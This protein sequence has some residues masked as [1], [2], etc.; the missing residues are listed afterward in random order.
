MHME[1][2]ERRDFK[3][4]EVRIEPVEGGAGRLY[5][6]SALFDSLSEDLG[7]FRERIAPGAFAATIASDDIRALFNHDSNNIL[8]RNTSGTLKLAEDDRGLVMAV[9]LPDTILARD[10]A[11][12]I[13]RGDVTGQS[14]GFRTLSDEWNM[15]DGEEIRTLKAVR[16]F[17]VGP[18]T[19]PAY[20]STTVAT[21]SLEAYRATL[22]EENKKPT[23]PP[24]AVRRASLRL[25]ELEI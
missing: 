16:L 21:R 3:F 19:F 8:G 25:A 17:D 7:G 13:E 1:L 23:F 10:L 18:V 20:P 2:L 15:E 11:V 24:L 9:D 4:L 5:G 12:S 22:A 14:F 6:H